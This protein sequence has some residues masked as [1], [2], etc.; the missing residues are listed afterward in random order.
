MVS[1]RRQSRFGDIVMIAFLAAQILDGFLTYRGIR[2]LGL[3]VEIEG[4]PLIALAIGALGVRVALILVKAIASL[5]GLF[6]HAH[7]Y[8]RVLAALTAL[9]V[10][11]AI[12]PWVVLLHTNLILHR[13]P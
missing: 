3:G 13:L 8:H 2:D 6:L 4:N 5:L 10:V 7:R 12:A 11:A 9:Y 1:L